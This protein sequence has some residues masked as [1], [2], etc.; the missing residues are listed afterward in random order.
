MIMPAEP[1]VG[2]VYRP[3][4]IPGFVFEEVTVKAV[5]RTLA[6][7]LGP[8]EGGLVVEELHMDDTKEVKTSRPGT[9]SS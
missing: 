3:E 8:V 2:D 7:P 6:G 9:A 1:K 5:D 4:N